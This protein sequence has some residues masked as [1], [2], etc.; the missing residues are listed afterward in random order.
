MMQPTTP[1]RAGAW[2]PLSWLVP[3]VIALRLLLFIGRGDYVAFDEGWYLLLGRNLMA[4]EGFSLSGLRHVTLS[5]LFPILAGATDL[6]LA[7]AVWSGRIVAAVAAGLLVIPCWS[8]F[9]RLSGRR[10]ATLA[11]VIVAALPGLAPF[12]VPYWIGRDLWVGAEPLLHLFLFTGIALVL[13]A[14]AH[15]RAR[16]WIAAG[17][18]FALAYLARPEAVLVFGFIGLILGLAALH[19]RSVATI[20]RLALFALAFALTSAPYWAY[21]HDVLGRWTL[22]GRG[23]EVS[24]RA[25]EHST[26]AAD[27]GPASTIERMLWRGDASLYVQRLYSLDA[28]G[29]RLASTYWG[30]PPAPRA[31]AQAAITERSTAAAPPH[32]PGVAPTGTAAVVALPGAA[33]AGVAREPTRLRLYGRAL[34]TILPW[35]TWPF[36]ALGVFAALART[37]SA[38][39]PRFVELLVALPL[40]CTSVAIARVVAIDP[41]T[42]LFILP[43]AAFYSARGLRTAGVQLHRRLRG[44]QIR[45]GF[46]QGALVAITLILLLGTQARWLYMSLG[47]GSPH[48]LAGASNREIGAALR[49]AMPPGATVMSWHPAIALYAGRDWRVLPHAE[50]DDIVRYA[51]AVRSEHVV[52]SRFYPGPQ[53]AVE[54]ASEHVVIRVPPVPGD[55]WTLQLS[56]GAAPFLYGELMP[57]VQPGLPPPAGTDSIGA[58]TAD[59]TGRTLRPGGVTGAGPHRSAR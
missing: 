34:A 36:V 9:R 39:H 7:N 8:I 4:G 53:L 12:V 48:H 51:L 49:Q 21:L 30:Y 45:R 28:S 26:S 23:I 43:L 19:A 56:R 22:T 46:V 32:G 35:F 37:R 59:A 25:A 13:R 16:D 54:A 14:R 38:R 52:I 5:P 20:G 15:G 33:P 2:H 50:L 47:V 6:L 40:L 17:G 11:C 58:V 1:P 10:T 44:T 31:P 3:A 18:A 29:T 41:R 55:S 24:V 57:V 27:A 42:Q